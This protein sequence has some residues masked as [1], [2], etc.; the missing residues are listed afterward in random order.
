MFAY[1]CAYTFLCVLCFVS[2]LG[3]RVLGLKDPLPGFSD[4]H[5]HAETD[6]I[7]ESHMAVDGGGWSASYFYNL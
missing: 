3:W 2:T 1:L 7:L 4:S 6:L 5:Q